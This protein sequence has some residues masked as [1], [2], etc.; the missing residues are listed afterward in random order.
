AALGGV[1]RRGIYDN[2]KTAV[3]RVGRG[4][5]RDVNDRFAALCAHYLRI[6]ANVTGHFGHRDRRC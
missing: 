1:A 5:K 2:M 6:S 4:K 3:D